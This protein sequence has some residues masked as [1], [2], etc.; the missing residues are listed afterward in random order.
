MILLEEYIIALTNL[1]GIVSKEKVV[2]I[3]NTQNEDKIGM[4]QVDIL[5]ESSEE[6]EK[7]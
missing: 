4:E 6:L 7:N 3:Y 5:Y 2:E 1:Y